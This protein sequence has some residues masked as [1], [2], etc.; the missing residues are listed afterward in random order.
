MLRD[1]AA[2]AGAV[3]ELSGD[4]AWTYDGLAATLG[5]LLGREVV[6]RDL[7]TEEHVAALT[8]A[9]LDEGTARFVAALDTNTRDGE[10]PATTG[11]LS[12]LIGRPTTPVGETLRALL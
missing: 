3:Y 8:G 6:Y 5:E 7:T 4:T 11:E 9:G 12:R 10:L 2:H 1:P